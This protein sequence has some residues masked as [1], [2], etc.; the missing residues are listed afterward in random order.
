MVAAAGALSAGIDAISALLAPLNGKTKTGISASSAFNVNG[1]QGT[2]GVT[3]KSGSSAGLL[4]TDTFNSLLSAQAQSQTQATADPVSTGGRSGALGRLFSSLDGNGDGQISK[5]EF[6]DKLG[7]G[8]TN[9]AN[10]ESVFGK[11]DTNGDGSISLEELTSALSAKKKRHHKPGETEGQDPLLK[12]LNGGSSSSSTNGDGSTTTTVTYADG[13][14]VT[15][16]KPASS[17]ASNQAASSYNFV[18][19]AIQQQA[20]YLS[21]SSSS[22]VSISA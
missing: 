14:K 5:A 15:L 3:S 9:T 6:N 1:P 10:A 22:T 17:T 12:A 16:T 13:T 19:R 8:G 21:A 4:T 7:A 2:T 20:R 18:E 11:I